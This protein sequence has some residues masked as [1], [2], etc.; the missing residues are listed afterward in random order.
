[1]Y[2]NLSI[3][4]IIF[5]C[6]LQNFELLVSVLKST[7]H[8]TMIL[9]LEFVY[10]PNLCPAWGFLIHGTDKTA[11]GKGKSDSFSNVLVSGKLLFQSQDPWSA[12]DMLSCPEVQHIVAVARLFLAD[13][14]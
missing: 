13:G 9:G 7:F 5:R 3:N 14:C 11:V 10:Y 6:F 2:K 8:G 12:E 1:M 4:C